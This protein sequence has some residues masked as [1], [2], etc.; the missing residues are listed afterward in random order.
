MHL[1]YIASN[2][3]PREKNEL[4]IKKLRIQVGNS[5]KQGKTKNHGVVTKNIVVIIVLMRDKLIEKHLLEYNLFIPKKLR[6][7]S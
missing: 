2:L 3:N 4:R 1:N 6:A 7:K 5:Y